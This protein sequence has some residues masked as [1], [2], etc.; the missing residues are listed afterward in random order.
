MLFS[1]GNHAG[2]M[3][4]ASYAPIPCRV[5]GRFVH[6]VQNHYRFYA[7]ITHFFYRLCAGCVHIF[8][9]FMQLL[10][11]IRMFNAGFFDATFADVSCA[12]SL[13]TPKVICRTLEIT[14]C[15]SSCVC[16]QGVCRL[17][18]Y[19][20]YANWIIPASYASCTLLIAVGNQEP[21]SQKVKEFNLEI[22]QSLSQ[23]IS[24]PCRQTAWKA[25][26]N[27]IVMGLFQSW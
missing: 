27:R 19:A 12:E 7:D 4:F 21:L 1:Y 20:I 25:A 5:C 15:T 18:F 23:L 2:F 17:R 22:L 26:P 8:V 13:Q 9:Y 11:I 14:L 16:M 24:K 6:F 10:C 3:H